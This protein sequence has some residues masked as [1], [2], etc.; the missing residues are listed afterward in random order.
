[1]DLLGRS[2]ICV[3]VALLDLDR[4]AN[5]P[6]ARHTGHTVSFSLPSSEATVWV[7][8]SREKVSVPVCR[9]ALACSSLSEGLEAVLSGLG[10]FGQR[11]EL[12]E[13]VGY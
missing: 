10:G 9:L 4:P 12:Q 8:G 5:T 3:E 11:H 2:S 1:M 7:R 6:K 13:E